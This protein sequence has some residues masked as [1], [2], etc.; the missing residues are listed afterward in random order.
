MDEVGKEFAALL[1]KK[2]ADAYGIGWLW[3]RKK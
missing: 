1:I 3:E 2:Q